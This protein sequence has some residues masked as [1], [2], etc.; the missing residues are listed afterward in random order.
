MRDCLTNRRGFDRVLM[1]VAAAFLTVST[2]SAMAQDPA[3]SSAAELAIDAAI[4]RP[5]PVNLPPPTI[6]DFKMDTTAAV[7]PSAKSDIK[8]DV[9]PEAATAPNETKPADTKPADAKPADAKPADTATAPA[10]APAQSTAAAPPAVSVPAASAPPA[11]VTADAP[12]AS[13]T[14]A[15][16][17]PASTSPALEPTKAASNVPP[18][19]QPVADKIKDM[20]AAKAQRY[21]DRRGERAAVE[22]F[23]GARDY[24]PLWTQGGGLTDNARGALA[25]LKDAASDGLN[26][27]DYPVPLSLLQ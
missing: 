2:T 15:S 10:I 3:R 5:E 22:K 12:A 11:P 17:T 24:A 23:Y 21:F 16:T 26:A 13:T 6:N 18:A 27:A 20:F 1:T 19:D 8:S 7:P 4:P 25:R 9:K 14:P